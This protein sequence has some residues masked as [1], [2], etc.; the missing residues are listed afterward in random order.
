MLNYTKRDSI[1][2]HYDKYNNH[3]YVEPNLCLILK[4]CFN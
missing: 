4:Y 3:D 1:G 2:S